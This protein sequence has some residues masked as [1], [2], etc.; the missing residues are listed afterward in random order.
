MGTRAPQRSN[1][2]GEHRSGGPPERPSRLWA[3]AAMSRRRP[4]RNCLQGRLGG[5]D[6]VI[7]KIRDVQLLRCFST[8]HSP[9]PLRAEAEQSRCAARRPHSL[10]SHRP[11]DAFWGSTPLHCVFPRKN[12]SR[13][14][15]L[16]GKT[17]KSTHGRAR[18]M[19][20]RTHSRGMPGARPPRCRR[21]QA[22]ATSLAPPGQP[23]TCSRVPDAASSRVLGAVLFGVGRVYP[24]APRRLL[25][26]A[27]CFLGYLAAPILGYLG[28][29]WGARGACS[30]VPGDLF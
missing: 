4:R 28:R 3:I 18:Q 13:K 8:A 19:W 27:R 15:D 23:R 6:A 5:H 20:I 12:I 16:Y 21:R 2:A 22:A 30:R 10:S 24:R 26:C 7:C 17:K 11:C 1:P 25:R 9:P 29:S 14:K